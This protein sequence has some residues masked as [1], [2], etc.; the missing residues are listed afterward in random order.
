MIVSHTTKISLPESS[1]LEELDA[2]LD[3]DYGESY[4]KVIETM[5]DY[6]GFDKEIDKEKLLLNYVNVFGSLAGY[7]SYNEHSFV[8]DVRTFVEQWIQEKGGTIEYVI[9]EL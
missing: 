5:S 8:V 2:K 7:N 9:E 6:I 4:L 1:L 3:S